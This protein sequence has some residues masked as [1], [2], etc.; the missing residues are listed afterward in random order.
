M[1][2]Q[3][4][5]YVIAVD[6]YRHFAKAADACFVTQPTLSMM[7]RKLEEELEVRLFDRSIQPLQ[8]TVIGLQIIEQIRLSLKHVKQIKEIAENE[9]NIVKGTFRLGIIPTI[10]PYLVPELIKKQNEK[11]GEIELELYENT[12]DFLIK[13]LLNG[14]LDGGLMAGPLN[15]EALN[16]HP[17]Y[18]EKFYAYVSPCDELY[19]EHKINLEEIDIRNIWLLKNIHCLRGQIELMCRKRKEIEKDF[20]SVT[21]EAGSIETLIHIVDHNT[22]ITIVPEMM[23]MGLNEERQ[24][25]LRNLNVDTYRE[26]SLAVNKEY[27]RNAMLRAI[28]DIIKSSVPVSMQDVNLKKFSVG[29]KHK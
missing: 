23:A 29:L 8:P 16:E 3:Q 10:A 19:Q 20:S 1:N 27:V 24:E 18:Y 13:S 5:E 6:N 2:I 22:G 4:L 9:R 11:H 21:Y 17:I 26:I 12:T 28:S 7:I 14:T 25:N 15:H